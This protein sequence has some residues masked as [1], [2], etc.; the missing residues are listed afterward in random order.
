[1]SFEFV[2]YKDCFLTSVRP[3]I[4]CCCAVPLSI[5]LLFF[6]FHLICLSILASGICSNRVASSLYYK[7]IV[8]LDIIAY[9]GAAG[10]NAERVR[11]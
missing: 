3:F 10:W 11:V 6:M 4:Y 5:E 9:G 8:T 1:M 2:D 7:G